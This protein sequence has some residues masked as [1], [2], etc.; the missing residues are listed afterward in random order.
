MEPDL[1]NP[2]PTKSMFKWFIEELQRVHPAQEA[3]DTQK[4]QPSY[5]YIGYQENVDQKKYFTGCLCVRV[6]Q[7]PLEY[8]FNFEKVAAP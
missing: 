4:H 7:Q 2:K 3:G 8:I 1:F 5:R 6:G